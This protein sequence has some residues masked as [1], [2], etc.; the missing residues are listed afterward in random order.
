[1]SST[2][3]EKDSLSLENESVHRVY[4]IIAYHFSD[5]RYKAQPRLTNHLLMLAVAVS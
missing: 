5:T 1:M 4:D 3:D 2:E